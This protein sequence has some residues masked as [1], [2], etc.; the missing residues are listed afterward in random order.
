[1]SQ[2]T[3]AFLPVIGQQ[4]DSGV[5]AL[6]F[7]WHWFGSADTITPRVDLP[8]GLVGV[9]RVACGWAS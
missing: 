6:F 1:M 3:Q 7:L 2:R 5:S 4:I 8:N 9:D